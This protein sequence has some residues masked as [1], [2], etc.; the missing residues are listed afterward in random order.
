MPPT[1][2]PA[3]DESIAK[4]KKLLGGMDDGRLMETWRLMNGD[5]ELFAIPRAGFLRAIMLNHWYHHR[6]QLTATFASWVFRSRR[7]TG[8]VPTRTRSCELDI[9]CR[10]PGGSRRLDSTPGRGCWRAG[11]PPRESLL[12]RGGWLHCQ[13]AEVRDRS[14]IDPQRDRAL[15]C[16]PVLTSLT[17]S[18][19]CS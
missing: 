13:V 7:S 2:L 10:E 14:A 11:I 8:R 15:P 5:R 1:L 12:L 9:D 3:L 6:G 19:G 18:V 17:T 4:A 16:A